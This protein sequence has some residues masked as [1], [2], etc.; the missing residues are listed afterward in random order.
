M[1]IRNICNT[2][3]H[4]LKNTL[5]YVSSEVMYEVCTLQWFQLSFEKWCLFFAN[6][7]FMCLFPC[8]LPY[9][10]KRKQVTKVKFLV[11]TEQI[12]FVISTNVNGKSRSMFYT[13]YLVNKIGWVVMHINLALKK[14]TLGT[15][16]YKNINNSN[17]DGTCMSLAS[18]C[19]SRAALFQQST[20]CRFY[21]FHAAYWHTQLTVYAIYFAGFLFSRI[22]RVGC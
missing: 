22:S 4:N 8:T 18:F 12:A 5:G 15:V 2:F 17:L 6:K 10:C 21:P 11:K 16:Q 7:L 19:Q 14:S 3:D 9:S 1:N 13:A 20:H